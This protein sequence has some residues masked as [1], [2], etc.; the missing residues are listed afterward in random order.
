MKLKSDVIWFL[1]RL[2]FPTFGIRRKIQTPILSVT[3][4]E[5]FV[6]AVYALPNET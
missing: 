4:T 2:I 5:I 3:Y 1:I 6:S